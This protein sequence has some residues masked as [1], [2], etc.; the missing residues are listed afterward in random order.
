MSADGIQMAKSLTIVH[1]EHGNVT[2]RMH[3]DQGLIFAIGSMELEVAVKFM[4][5]L[6]EEIDQ[7]LFARTGD[8]KSGSSDSVH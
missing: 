1:C 4:G 8:R 3:D 5:N 6:I 2:I 7:A